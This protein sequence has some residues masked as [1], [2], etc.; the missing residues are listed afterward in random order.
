MVLTF[1]QRAC[2]ITKIP[3]DV[4]IL[5]C[6]T[7]FEQTSH[8]L[9]VDVQLLSHEILEAQMKDTCASQ[10]ACFRGNVFEISTTFEMKSNIYYKIE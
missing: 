10:H 5:E 3:Q 4:S 6:M 1:A 8:L 2:S 9:L 7:C